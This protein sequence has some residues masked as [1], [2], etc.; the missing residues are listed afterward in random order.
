MVGLN[1]PLALVAEQQLLSCLRPPIAC[2][3]MDVVS[4]HLLQPTPLPPSAPDRSPVLV[5]HFWLHP[6]P[7]Q[8]AEGARRA[9]DASV[10]ASEQV[11]TAAGEQSQTVSRWMEQQGGQHQMGGRWRWQWEGNITLYSSLI[12]LVGIL[13]G[14]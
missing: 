6:R 11:G 2:C 3:R 7:F 14:S 10:E 1:Q 8:G 13:R 4:P 5:L 9:R 12:T